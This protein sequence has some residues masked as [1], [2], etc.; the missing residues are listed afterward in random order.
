MGS[1][2]RVRGKE[3]PVKDKGVRLGITPARAG[4]RPLPLSCPIRSR[5]HPRACGEKAV[6]RIDRPSGLGS[7]PR[8]RGKAPRRGSAYRRGRITPARAGKR[9]VD[10]TIRRGARDHP[11]ACG[12]KL[13]AM[14]QKAGIWGSPPRVR[15]KVVRSGVRCVGIGITPARAGKRR[16]TIRAARQSRDHPRACGEKTMRIFS[17]SRITGSPPRVRG[18]AASGG[19]ITIPVRITPARAGKRRNIRS[20]TPP[21]WDH[22]RAC[23][24]KQ[25]STSAWLTPRGS[26]PRVRGK[27]QGCAQRERDRG[28]TPARAG[29]SRAA[30]NEA[31]PA[32]DHP[33]ACGEKVPIAEMRVASP[34]SPPRVRG[35]GAGDFG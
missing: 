15:G 7:P 35:K 10:P 11:R 17:L 2:P 30:I 8:V 9:M 6:R 29:K 13:P 31:K 14:H 1:P 26:P 34:G 22:P 16:S 23:G 32:Q 20:T 27:G 4:K 12:E 21:A 25:I 5:D 19:T 3:Q 28:I 24:E 33:R 18:K